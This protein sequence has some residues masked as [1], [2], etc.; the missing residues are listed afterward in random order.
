MALLIAL[1]ALSGCA[2]STDATKKTEKIPSSVTLLSSNGDLKK[3][4]GTWTSNCGRE[5]RP[6]PAGGAILA[7]GINSFSF[8]SV[9]ANALVG[10]LTIDSYDSPD[11]SGPN[12][13]TTANV[14]LSYLGNLPVESSLGE[15][16]RYTGMA[17]KVSATV[18][19]M[20]GA[21]A[22]NVGFIDGFNKFELSPLDFFSSTNLVYTKK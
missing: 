5:Y 3:Y 20:N 10:T 7:S 4:I 15:R 18:A 6:G 2:T 12:K 19:G 17:D 22:F 21:S 8:T 1:A 11:C 13:Q 14:T 16:A 9:S